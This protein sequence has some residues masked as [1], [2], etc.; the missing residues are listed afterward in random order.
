M[1]IAGRQNKPFFEEN[2]SKSTCNCDIYQS[3]FDFQDT[4]ETPLCA[5]N[6]DSLFERSVMSPRN[7][8]SKTV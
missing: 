4:L 1:S 5:E 7:R 8:R 2:L 6:H 3:Y